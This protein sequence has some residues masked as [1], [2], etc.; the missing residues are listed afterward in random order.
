MKGCAVKVCG[1]SRNVKGC[2]VKVCGVCDFEKVCG[3]GMVWI[4]LV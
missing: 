4:Q 2:A 3:H 1:V